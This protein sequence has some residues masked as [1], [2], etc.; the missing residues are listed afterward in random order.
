MVSR[1]KFSGTKT[2]LKYQ[3][4]EISQSTFLYQRYCFLYILTLDISN[5]WYLIVNFL[6]PENLLWNISG[7]RHVKVPS[8][9]KD[10]VFFIF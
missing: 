3:W 8:Y 9:I 10:I 7:L 5:H 4:F 2:T 1:S 6:G